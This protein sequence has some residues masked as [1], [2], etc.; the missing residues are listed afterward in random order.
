MTAVSLLLE[1]LAMSLSVRV[2]GKRELVFCALSFRDPKTGT[3]QFVN[4][5]SKDFFWVPEMKH[6]KQTP[7]HYVE[8]LLREL[9]PHQSASATS[10]QRDGGAHRA[11]RLAWKGL[12]ESSR[13]PSQ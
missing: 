1:L 9:R 8:H 2:L 10:D 12:F 3:L 11:E 6:A 5:N 13:G 7:L 4:L